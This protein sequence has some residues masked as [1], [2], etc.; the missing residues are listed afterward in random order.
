MD[1][2]DR[3]Q[4][5]VSMR[6][7]LLTREYPPNIYG[8]AGV[9]VAE[10]SKVLAAHANVRVHAFDGPRDPDV[11]DDVTVYG[12]DY[13]DGLEGNDA[14]RTFGVDLQMVSGAEGA[15]IVH[16][17]TWYAN[18]GGHLAGL[19]HNIPHVVSA[20]SLEPLRPWKR[21]QL[22][23][24]YELSSFAER[25]AYEGA[26][27][28]IAVS[29][30]MR[31]DILRSY[32]NVDP[33]RVEVIHNGIDLDGWKRPDDLE[34]A[35]EYFR[36]YGL[37]P[38]RPTIIFVGRITRQKGLPHF[39]RA[40]AQLPDEIQ[41]ILCAGRPDTEEIAEEV[42]GL[43]TD[44]QKKRDGIVW[45]DEHLPR[46]KLIA[47]QVMSTTFVTPSIYEPLGIVNLEA[48]ACGL[49]VVGSDTGGIPDCIVHDETGLLVPIDQLDDGTGTPKHPDKFEADLASALAEVCSD[50]ERAKQMGIA[51][52]TRV[53]EQFSWETIAEKTIDFYTRVIDRFH[54]S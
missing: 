16:S 29:R 17:H 14:I 50:P 49:P 11:V 19:L 45:I 12:Y 32:P 25:T 10:L 52:R 43:V 13:L 37:D 6:V 27:G 38:E 53:E 41:V 35:E 39:L 40:V 31:D 8:G 23:G 30:A 9:H 24:G 7:D 18:L 34:E 26:A 20:H 3:D 44:L 15:D 47:L 21:E 54:R 1:E 36:S 46:E 33:D 2:T 28:I 51:G 4:K 42:K 22:G 48:M 5:G